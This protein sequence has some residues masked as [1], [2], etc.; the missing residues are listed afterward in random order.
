MRLVFQAPPVGG[1]A[2]DFFGLQLEHSAT[3]GW[4]TEESSEMGIAPRRKH[5]VWS[6]P[7]FGFATAKSS[8]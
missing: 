7:S 3:M 4:A 5:Y 6:K 2:W 8:T 1:V